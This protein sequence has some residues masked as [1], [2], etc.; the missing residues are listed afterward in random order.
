[1]HKYCDERQRR[2]R[3]DR[4]GGHGRYC[5]AGGDG[6]PTNDDFTESG[7]SRLSDSRNRR[8][9]DRS[10]FRREESDLGHYSSPDGEGDRRRRDRDFRLAARRAPK[11]LPVIWPLNDLFTKAVDYSTYR[12]K[13]RSANYDASNARRINRYGK[14]LAVQMMTHTL[15]S[16]D[17]IALLGFSDALKWPVTTMGS[18]KGRPYGVSSSI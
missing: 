6:Y 7:D 3:D 12:L 10:R 18:A 17:L 16:Q 9:S 13:S 4:D 11:R 14:N 5:D 2:Y 1:M 8:A 15:R